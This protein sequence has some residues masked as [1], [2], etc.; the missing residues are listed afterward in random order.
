MGVLQSSRVPASAESLPFPP[1]PSA[2]IAGRTMQE[3]VYRRREAPRRLPPDGVL[4]L[5]GAETVLGVTDRFEPVPGERGIYRL[6]PSAAPMPAM[7]PLSPI[8]MP[9]PAMAAVAG[10]R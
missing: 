1:V 7:V 3:S 6:A 8:A 4:F 9:A 10:R 5:G 2:S